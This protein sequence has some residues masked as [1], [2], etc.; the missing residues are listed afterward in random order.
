M[1]ATACRLVQLE[2][3]EL[4][5]TTTYAPMSIKALG[6]DVWEGIKNKCACMHHHAW[7][8][9]SSWNAVVCWIGVLHACVRSWTLDEGMCLNHMLRS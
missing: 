2:L 7:V 9:R 4:G 1:H 6:E 3:A 5:I 8:I